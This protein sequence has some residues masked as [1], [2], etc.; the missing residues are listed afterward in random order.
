MSKKIVARAL[1]LSTALVL[2]AA[3]AA[4][5][6]AQP[7]VCDYRGQTWYETSGSSS[8]VITHVT[9]YH[10]SPGSSISVTKTASWE[11]SLTA[12]ISVTTG[13]T[14][15]ASGIIASAEASLSVSLSASGTATYA[16]SESI[17]GT[18]SSATVDRY[19]AAYAGRRYYTGSWTKKYC[20]LT[21]VSTVGSGSWRSF[22]SNLEGI[23]LCPASR[24]ASTSLAYK[25]CKLTWS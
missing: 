7:T 22:Q 24:Y 6:F 18:V 17:T 20:N 1:V 3:L 11:K 14:I 10:V 5:A 23:A 25:A 12:G 16:G 15:S 8:Y 9:G 21:S 19:Y 13:A 4:P 2:P